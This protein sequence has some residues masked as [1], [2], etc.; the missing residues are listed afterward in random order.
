[1]SSIKR[2]RCCSQ[3]PQP[4][5]GLRGDDPSLSAILFEAGAAAK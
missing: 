4:F 3:P 1:M 5:D 2:S